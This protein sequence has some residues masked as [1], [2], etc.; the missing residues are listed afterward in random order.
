MVW[1]KNIR[2]ETGYLEKEEDDIVTTTDQVA[3]KIEDG[4]IKE[5]AKE[6]PVGVEN[7][8]DGKNYLAS[9]S[10][11]DNHTHLDKGH[12]GGG[13]KAVVPVSGVKERIIEEEGFQ[14]MIVDLEPLANESAEKDLILSLT[15]KQ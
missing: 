3:L 6:V 7:V 9:P 4:T 11:S 1:I 13:W 12:Y 14:T 2:L 5:I 15:K 8:I 10:L